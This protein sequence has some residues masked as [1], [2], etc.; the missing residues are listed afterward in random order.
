MIISSS[1]ELKILTS[2]YYANN[3]FDKIKTILLLEHEVI[4]KLVSKPVYE[5]AKSIYV[6]AGNDDLEGT[7]SP[8]ASSI[9]K[10]LLQHLQL[11]I[12][13]SA[14]Y[15]FYQSN[16]VSHEDS[17]RKIKIDKNNES[18]AW[19]WMIDRDDQAHQLAIQKSTDRLIDFLNSSGITEWD[20]S[21]EKTACKELFIPNTET[22]HQYFPVDHSGSFYHAVRP[23]ITDI[24]NRQIT[25]ALG[26]DFKHLLNSFKSNDVSE[27]KKPLL[28][29]VQ[30]ALALLTMAKAVKRLAVQVFPEGVVQQFKSQFGTINSSQFPDMEIMRKYSLYLERDA[31]IA[32]DEIRKWRH[33][34]AEDNPQNLL[35]KNSST[36][37]FART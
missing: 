33:T 37:K 13:L 19:E 10:E 20:N 29:L 24:Q 28:G 6:P 22:F 32:L 31:E 26:D 23:F 11:P 14:A 27:E 34:S 12:A 36:R 4:K 25:K 3:D 8:D 18:M 35:P 15:R 7:I 30:Q 16:L 5:L 9:H 2:S 1:T 21:P 17:S